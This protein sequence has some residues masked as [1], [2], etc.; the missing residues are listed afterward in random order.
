MTDAELAARVCRV[1]GIVRDVGTEEAAAAVIA[2]ASPTVPTDA[3]LADAAHRWR[4]R[5]QAAR[6]RD[7]PH[8]RAA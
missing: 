8:R 5:W 4:L 7:L 1:Q 3:A 6:A 2:S